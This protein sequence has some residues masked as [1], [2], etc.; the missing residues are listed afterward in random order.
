MK[1][2]LRNGTQKNSLRSIHTH[3]K[4]IMEDNSIRA[5]R[6]EVLGDNVQKYASSSVSGGGGYVTTVNGT[7]YGQIQGVTTEVNQHVDQDI[8]VKDIAA[9]KELQLNIVG[10]TLPVRPGHVLRIAFDKK[11][12]RW[13]RLVNE[14]T[15]MS[16][17]GNGMV[18]PS[19]AQEFIK[20]GNKGILLAIGLAIPMVNWIVGLVALRALWVTSPANMYGAKVPKALL[21]IFIATLA[22]IGLFVLGTY[23]F[24]I[25]IV[26]PSKHSF[27]V[28]LLVCGGV[29]ASFIYFVKSYRAMHRD[30][31]EMVKE[32]SALLDKSVERSAFA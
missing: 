20:E 26:D 8:W 11:T 10:T 19:R 25:V 1:S 13:E 12:E 9:G 31:A 27:L 3:L 30:A 28:Q 2:L 5:H 17:Y 6:V 16:D 23:G 24:I 15:G 4:K 14:T 29:A 18:N 32:R 7:T 21:R 22:G